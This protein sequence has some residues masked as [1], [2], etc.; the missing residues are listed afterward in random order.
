[1]E[2]FANQ[3]TLICLDWA[4]PD[5][6][7]LEVEEGDRRVKRLARNTQQAVTSLK[8]KEPQ[9]KE[10]RWPLEAG[11]GKKTDSSLEPPE[12]IQPS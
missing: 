8:M 6:P 12:G 11:K 7:G 5:N 4:Y 3:L 9:A 1:M 2:L 10:C